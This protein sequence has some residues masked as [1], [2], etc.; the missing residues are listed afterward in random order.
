MTAPS[1]LP[2]IYQS[3]A[4][5]QSNH[6]EALIN[7]APAVTQR[8]TKDVPV[9]A[10]GVD[11]HQSR[12]ATGDIS[13]HQCS[14]HFSAIDLAF[15]ADHSEIGKLCRQHFFRHAADKTLRL[16]TVANQFCNGKH[17]QTM[18]T[19][20]LDQVGHARHGAIILHDLADHAGGRE[21]SHSGK[22]H[23]GLRLARA[24]ENPSLTR[25][26]WKH[27]SRAREVMRS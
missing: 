5:F 12:F 9:K 3:A 13:Q 16:K 21:S 7:D 10:L 8:A 27:V 4:A 25:P 14:V 17:F 26:E 1:K 19:A 2:Q 22:V 15:E 24:Y 20:E 11:A 18:L 6:S 23:R